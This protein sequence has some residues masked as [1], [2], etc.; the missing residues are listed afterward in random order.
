MWSF[1]RRR[2]DGSWECEDKRGFV[3]FIADNATAFPALLSLVQ[4]D[5]EKIVQHVRETGSVPPGIKI[6]KTTTSSDDNVTQLRVFH[7]PTTIPEN[8]R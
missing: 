6:V 7:G 1:I 2:D 4:P 8:E 5:E 3:N